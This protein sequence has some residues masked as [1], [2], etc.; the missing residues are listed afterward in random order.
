MVVGIS[1]ISVFVL[2][3]GGGVGGG[4]SVGGVDDVDSFDVGGMLVVDG[5]NGCMKNI[6]IIINSVC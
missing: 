6:A 3:S 4:D 2:S 1:F 5:T